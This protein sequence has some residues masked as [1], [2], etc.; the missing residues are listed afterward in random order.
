[1]CQLRLASSGGGVVAAAAGDMDM[2]EGY[3]SPEFDLPPSA[4]DERE[5]I[6]PKKRRKE[7]QQFEEYEEEWQG[8]GDLE[9]LA[10][11]A[12]GAS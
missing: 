2:D 3:A 12:L 10:L 1:M 9:A 4:E 5:E 8:V 7:K 6:R 11:Q